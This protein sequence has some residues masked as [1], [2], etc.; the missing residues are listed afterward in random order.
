MVVWLVCTL[1]G[2]EMC[3][4]DRH[5]HCLHIKLSALI[6]LAE[7]CIIAVKG[8]GVVC[9]EWYTAPGGKGSGV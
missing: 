8:N 2:P 6:V 1:L 4:D 7:P 9:A 5:K 3:Q